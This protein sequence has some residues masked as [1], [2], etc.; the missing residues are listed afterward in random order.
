MPGFEQN[1]STNL[2]LKSASHLA[3]ERSEI[4]N[5]GGTQQIKTVFNESFSL[6]ANVTN[7][8]RHFASFLRELGHK[9]LQSEMCR[10]F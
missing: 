7:V 2:K 9:R 3:T 6:A 1:H 10:P 5:N 8:T 4:L